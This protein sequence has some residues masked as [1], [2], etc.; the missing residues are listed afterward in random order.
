MEKICYVAGCK[1]SAVFRGM[2][3]KHAK[4]EQEIAEAQHRRH[5]E[6]LV[7]AWSHQ[8]HVELVLGEK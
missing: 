1:N 6:H 5:L 4:R 2:C 8:S 7:E 3:Q